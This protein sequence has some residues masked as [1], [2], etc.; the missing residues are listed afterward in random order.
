MQAVHCTSGNAYQ[1]I[2]ES[3]P[4]PRACRQT[5]ACYASLLGSTFVPFDKASDAEAAALAQPGTVDAL[6]DFTDLFPPAPPHPP[7]RL[8]G[9]GG[10]GCGSGRSRSGS[11]GG[12]RG[13][14][15]S[16]GDGGAEEGSRWHRWG[17]AAVPRLVAAPAPSQAPLDVGSMGPQRGC[18]DYRY[19]LR[20]NH[21]DTPLTRLIFNKFDLLAGGQY[22]C[23]NTRV[24]G[25]RTSV[26]EGEHGLE[27]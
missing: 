5:E 23:V 10:D 8:S 22:R 6:L 20:L 7:G 18:S 14:S 26:C 24:C 25:E 9:G 27:G 2:N 4:F 12:R 11:D 17:D 21:T 15:R 1:G 3:A 19:T 13:S 16:G